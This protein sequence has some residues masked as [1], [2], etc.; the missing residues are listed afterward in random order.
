M[1][2]AMCFA[3]ALLLAC[4][5]G[6]LSSC[7]TVPYTGRSQFIMTSVDEEERMGDEAWREVL[8][9]YKVSNNEKYNAALARTGKEIAIAA[10][11]PGYMWDFRV[12]QADEANAF[13]LPGG[14][15]AVF[16]GIFKY[17]ANDA[18]LAAVVGH[19]VGHAVARHGGERMSQQIVQQVGAKILETS[20]QATN[21]AAA[22]AWLLA[23][24][25]VSTVGVILPYSRTQEYEADRIGMILMAK[26][27]YRPEAAISL[28]EKFGKL[29]QTGPLSEF[30]STHPMSSKRIEEMRNIL[31]EAQEYYRQSRF[32]KDLG[33][34]LKP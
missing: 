6:L 33:E 25:G 11:Q 24:G 7:Y 32:K 27:G 2:S 16:S 34:S 13:C 20:L 21:T 15:V 1:K 17:F 19:E 14:K 23:Y 29:S 22:D 5:A 4:L 8:S 10:E 30:L 18:E 9:K 12:L 28:W 3:Q 26:A 31:P